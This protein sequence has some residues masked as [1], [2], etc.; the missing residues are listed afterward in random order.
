[1]A[2]KFK[3]S[4]FSERDGS[5]L[6]TL[7]VDDKL[8]MTATA[9]SLKEFNQTPVIALRGTEIEYIVSQK[10][11]WAKWFDLSAE[12]ELEILD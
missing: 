6:T 5:L 7:D 10:H 1:M 12:W 2:S 3:I 4:V 11:E 8:A 9:M